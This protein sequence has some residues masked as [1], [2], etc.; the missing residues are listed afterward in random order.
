LTDRQFDLALVTVG[1]LVLLVG[2]FSRALASRTVLT[3]P[4]IAL[5]AGVLLGPAVLGWLEPARWGRQEQFLEDV[6]RLT[7]AIGLMAVAL[8]LPPRFSRHRASSLAVLLGLLMPLMWLAA[9]LAIHLVLGLPLLVALL[10]GAIVTPTDPVVAT[11]VVTGPLARARVPPR[12]RHLISAESG[13]NDGLAYPIVLLAAT[14]LAVSPAPP[15]TAWLLRHVVW[16]VGAA[17]L[18]GTAMGGA[19]AGLVLPWDRWAELGW[20]APAVVLAVLLLRRLPAAV[21]LAPLVPAVRQARDA[22]FVGWFGPMGASAIFYAMLALRLT[23][24]EEAW[25]LAS[26]LIA[27]SLVAHGVTATPMALIYPARRP[28]SAEGEREAA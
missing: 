4:L 10:V 24:R 23:G 2:L 12:I 17:L 27:G 7:L 15:V 16:E 22:V 20:R 19:A 3:G 26:L 5:L 14:L 6:A 21:L 9:G 8:R 11:S 18:I 13:F 25:V 28:E 1:G